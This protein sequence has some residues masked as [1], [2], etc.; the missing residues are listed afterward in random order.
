MLVRSAVRSIVISDRC[1]S[2]TVTPGV[3]PGESADPGSGRA[4]VRGQCLAQ[5]LA[6]AH[7]VAHQDERR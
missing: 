2:S 3:L 5:P 7:D 4:R 6:D 1:G